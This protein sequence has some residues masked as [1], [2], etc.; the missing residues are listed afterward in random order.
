MLS[1]AFDSAVSW[2]TRPYAA[3]RDVADREGSIAVVPVGSVEQ[4]GHHLPVATDSILAATVGTE[5]AE[6]AADD[7]PVLV[8]PPVWTGYSPHHL[9]FGGTVTVEHET[10]R[11]LLE[12]VADAVLSNGFDTLLF[13]N[14]H[15]GNASLIESV[16]STVG[17]DHPDAEILG[18]T[19][20]DLAEPFADELRDSDPG[21]MAHGG[22]F[23]TSLLLHLYPD[24]V[25]EDRAGSMPEEPYDDAPVDLFG[26]GPL[27]VYR[28]FGDYSES[29]AIGAPEL[30]S[31]EKGAKLYDGTADELA[32]LLRDVH[33]HVTDE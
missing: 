25:G 15:G 10:L 4:H 19:Y 5:G 24:L 11:T 20:F 2:A 30:A 26:G 17:V 22:E 16:T 31:A 28:P 18:L 13:L 27:S 12:D 23:E 21:G 33:R 7:V 32:E 1:G 8:T 9:A 14:G 29:G 3:I 6:R